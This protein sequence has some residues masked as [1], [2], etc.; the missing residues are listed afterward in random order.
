MLDM[1]L[2]GALPT[3][4]M[5]KGLCVL[6]GTGSVHASVACTHCKRSTHIAV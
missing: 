6:S 1:G 4:M 5:A 2:S 3:K